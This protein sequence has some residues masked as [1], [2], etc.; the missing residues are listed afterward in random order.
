MH[1]INNPTQAATTNDHPCVRKIHF[2]A[3]FGFNH[4]KGLINGKVPTVSRDLSGP[5]T[6]LSPFVNVSA[7]LSEPEIKHILDMVPSARQSCRIANV[8]MM[9]LSETWVLCLMCEKRFSQSVSTL[10]GMVPPN[11]DSY[12]T[13]IGARMSTNSASAN[14]SAPTVLRATLRRSRDPQ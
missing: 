2:P 10:T 1:W 11:T 9:F 7:G 3:V 13:L 6:P 5:T 14:T 4:T 12:I 8:L